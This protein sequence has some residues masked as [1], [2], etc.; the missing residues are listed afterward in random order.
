MK[1]VTLDRVSK[2]YQ[3]GSSGSRTIREAL[4][5]S[6]RRVAS[7]RDAPR[8]AELEQIVALD[9]VSLAVEQGQ[10]V[11]F[12]GANGSG[13]TTVL[14]LLAH[15]VYPSSGRVGVYG[16]VASLIE[17]GAGFHPELS[18][19]ENVYLYGSIMGMRRADVRAKFDQIVRFAELEEF[20]ETPVKR[21]SSGMYVRLG[22]AV[23]AHLDPAV[24][25]LDEVL[26]VGDAQFQSKCLTRIE[27]LRRSGT[28]IVFVSH[29]MAA[30]ERLCDRAFWLERG[31]VR[32]EGAPRAVV[33]DYYDGMLRRLAEADLTGSKPNVL[34]SSAEAE[35]IDVC[36]LDSTHQPVAAI[37][38]GDTLLAELH[39]RVNGT[40][41][42]PVFELFFYSLDGRLHCQYT[43]A[44]KTKPI[45]ELR[46]SGAVEFTCGEVGLA[47][48]AYR[49]AATIS[50]RDA[51]DAYCRAME[52]RILRVLPGKMPRGLFYSPHHWRLL[53]GRD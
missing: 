25:L 19:R 21:Y 27:E 2:R 10:S 7:G 52:A 47:P 30:V 9:D 15:I 29:D 6:L 24:L 12:V 46:G 53:P 5:D 13:K 28:T 31:R 39:Y 32:S 43:T 51:M 35:I 48:G 18:G 41:Q 36:L 22:F 11:G 1:I 8:A 44:S 16:S 42:A 50:R 20:V 45:E 3:R 38:T 14:K 40:L 37:A 34:A 49:V 33:R 23:A 4:V 26:A 17:V